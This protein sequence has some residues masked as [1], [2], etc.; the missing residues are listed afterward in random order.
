QRPAA[1][2]QAELAGVDAQW[3]FAI[4]HLAILPPEVIA[5]PSG[6]AVN[7]HDGPLPAYAGLNAPAWALINGETTYGISWH[8]ITPGVDEGDVLVQRLFELAPQETSLSLN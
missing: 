1:E 6:G 4:T 5:A 3:L 2:W 8:E 7:F